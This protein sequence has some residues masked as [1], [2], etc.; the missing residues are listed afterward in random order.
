M[1][2]VLINPIIQTR[3]RH[4]CHVHH[5]TCDNINAKVSSSSESKCYQLYGNNFN[6]LVMTVLWRTDPLL[7]SDSV[8]SGRC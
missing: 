7:S 6:K 2:S 5:P 1:E 8:N 4:F 3:T